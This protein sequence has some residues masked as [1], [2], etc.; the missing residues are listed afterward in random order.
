MVILPRCIPCKN[1]SV[2]VTMMA[3]VRELSGATRETQVVLLLQAVMEALKEGLTIAMTQMMAV[4]QEAGQICHHLE[5]LGAWETMEIL[6]R[7]IPYKSVL[8]TVT[9]MASVQELLGATS[10]AL[11][12]RLLLA[13]LEGHLEVPTTATTRMMSLYL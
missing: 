12:I 13:A 5:P 3:S 10:V 11:V 4:L 7:C 6:H 1:V 8:V 9:M 2:T